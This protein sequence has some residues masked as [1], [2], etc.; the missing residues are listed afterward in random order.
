MILIIILILILL[1]VFSILFT[2]GAG[3]QGKEVVGTIH[4]Y[5]YSLYKGLYRS[6]LVIYRALEPR[7]IAVMFIP[8]DN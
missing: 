3:L 8:A 6:I 1:A 2:G 4:E 5:I 7:S